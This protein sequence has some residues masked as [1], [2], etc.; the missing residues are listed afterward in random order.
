MKTPDSFSP[1]MVTNFVLERLS[2]RKNRVFRHPF[3]LT[4]CHEKLV[5]RTC[6]ND[7]SL[8][9]FTPERRT[10]SCATSSVHQRDFRPRQTLRRSRPSPF[11]AAPFSGSWHFFASFPP[12]NRYSPCSNPPPPPSPSPNLPA[13]SDTMVPPQTRIKYLQRS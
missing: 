6:L 8:P 2:E 4:A 11:P 1:C 9:A 13:Q 10:R 3:P 5:R 12:T 7:T